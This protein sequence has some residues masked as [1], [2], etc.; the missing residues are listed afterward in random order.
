M[1]INETTFFSYIRNAPFGGRLTTKQVE[2]VNIILAEFNKRRMKNIR[3]L[4]YILATAFHETGATMQPVVENL[5]YSAEGLMRTFKKY[6]PNRTAAD[7]Y[8]RKP[9]A[10]AN[11]VYANRMGNGP[12]SSGDGWKYRGRGYPQLTGFENYNKYGLAARPDDMLNAVIAVAVMFDGMITGA[13]TGKKLDDFFNNTTD[14]PEGART[15]INAMDKAKLI[16]G[17]YKSF[18]DALVAAAVAETTGNIPAEVR[19]IDAKPDDV[20]A[21]QSGTA[22]TAAAGTA[23]T[24]IAVPMIGGIDNVYAL[25]FSLALLGLAAFMGFMFITGRWQVNRGKAPG[26]VA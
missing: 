20:P 10:I 16:A 9:Q 8:A 26:V 7:K 5:N 25:I 18:Y 12:E 19:L 13:F 4:A 11:Y 6:F 23:A 17:Y 24:G 1:N 21:A 2:G 15:I 14:N 22:W 3:H